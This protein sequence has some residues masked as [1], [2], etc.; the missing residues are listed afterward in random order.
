MDGQDTCSFCG[1]QAER[2]CRRCSRSYCAEHGS[3]F[4]T[5]CSDPVSTLPSGRYFQVAVVAL[6][7]CLILGLWFLFGSPTLPGER[8]ARQATAAPTPTA[9]TASAVPTRTPPSATAAAAAATDYTVK[10]GDT[11]DLIATANGV[12]IPAILQLNPAIDPSS[13][14]IGQILHMPARSP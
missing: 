8:P 7:V 9:R 4:C 5:A 10:P 3:A 1:Q 6:P 14:Q 2:R 13:L 12:T 11:L